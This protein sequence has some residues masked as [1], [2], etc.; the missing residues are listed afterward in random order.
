MTVYILIFVLIKENVLCFNIK[1]A[2]KIHNDSDGMVFAYVR[3]NKPVLFHE[4]TVEY[5][6]CNE[7]HG[8]FE[9]ICLRIKMM[10]FS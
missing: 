4:K 3:T 9:N 1:N 8:F 6:I 5:M 2:F 10:K 7:T